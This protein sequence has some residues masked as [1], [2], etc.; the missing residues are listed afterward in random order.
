M[1]LDS[2]NTENRN[3]SINN[4]I[5]LTRRMTRCCSF[6]KIPGH[7]ITNCSSDRLLEFEVI[8]ADIVKNMNTYIEFK[9]WLVENY[10]NDLL[11]IKAFTIRKSRVSTNDI[12][13]Q[14]D[15]I[16]EYIFSTYKNNSILEQYVEEEE[17]EEE[18]QNIN[19]NDIENDLLNLLLQIRNNYVMEPLQEELI[20]QNMERM[21]QL[22]MAIAY[23]SNR[24]INHN[25]NNIIISRK[26]L[27]NCTL[28]NQTKE[29]MNKKSNCSI[30]YDNKKLKN[31]VVYDCNHEFCDICVI[32][33]LQINP[34]SIPCCALC[35]GE[36]K[37]IKTRT[38]E[39]NAKIIE[40]I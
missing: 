28:N 16:T 11:L 33:T 1:N 34:N 9:N 25:E 7:N 15:L 4:P 2:I 12:S 26:N 14:Y 40:S 38:L 13:I 35:R 21:L 27:I 5:R 31:F 36:V 17:N 24:Y 30:C 29:N 8:C 20:N 10:S 3:N 37:N 39:I 32:K 19:D 23:L 18:N 6:C 22:E